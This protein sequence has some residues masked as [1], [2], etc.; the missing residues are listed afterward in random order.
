MV[1]LRG[2]YPR[3]G[4]HPP[5]VQIPGRGPVLERGL[6]RDQAA[7]RLVQVDLPG[8]P[9][10]R[11]Q[12]LDGVVLHPGPH[13]LPDDP[14]QVGEHPE[15]EQVI[16][17]LLT[18]GEAAH[19]GAH[20][21]LACPV[22]FGE[23]ID[24]RGL[25]MVVVIHVQAGMSRPAF[26][27]EV[28]QLLERTLLARPVKGPDLR[29]PGP[30]RLIHLSRVDDAE[31]V[32]QPELPAVLRVV[33]CALD[34]EEQVPGGR[35]RQ[36]R[37]PA[38]GHQGTLGVAVGLQDLV[39]DAPV[40]AGHL[41]PGLPVS[42]LQGSRAHP[43][44]DGENSQAREL[45]PGRDPGVLQLPPLAR[46]HPGHQ[47]Q[48]VVTA[49]AVPEQGGPAAGFG[50]GQRALVDELDTGLDGLRGR[51]G[52]LGVRDLA[53]DDS[54]PSARNRSSTARSWTSPRRTRSSKPMSRSCGGRSL[55][56][57]FCRSSWVRCGQARWLAT[58]LADSRK[59]PSVIFIR[60]SW[61]SVARAHESP[62]GIRPGPIRT[63]TCRERG[64]V[65]GTGGCRGWPGPPS[66]GRI[67]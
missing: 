48:V 3:P 51:L 35:F 46:R 21:L 60:G 8:V 39:P 26:G 52:R 30:A 59:R 7:R 44:Q 22:Q 56:C 45:A 42:A 43:A 4:P 18:G 32:L 6:E 62:F 13:A 40:V 41:Q 58:S 24:R 9:G 55:P 19:Q 49:P 65:A 31:Q 67:G 47:G 34:V 15:P 2:A 33:P 37:Q 10:Q 17:L 25:V 38:I 63:R 53:D 16:H 12:P 66:R 14:V 50:P 11:L 64:R 20:R 1:C 54:C 61:S 23:V 28:D 57:A 5:P 27:D 29:V 36:G